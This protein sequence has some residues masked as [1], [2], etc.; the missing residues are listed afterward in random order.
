VRGD[1]WFRSNVGLSASVQYEKWIF[2]VILPTAQRD[3]TGSIEI[4][5]QPQKLFRRGTSNVTSESSP[6]GAPQ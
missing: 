3:V 5:F 2:P 4:L 1:Y 6:D